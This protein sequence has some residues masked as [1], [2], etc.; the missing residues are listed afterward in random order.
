MGASLGERERGGSDPAEPVTTTATTA[1]NAAGAQV[2]WPCYL[3]YLFCFFLYSVVFT[4]LIIHFQAIR[5]KGDTIKA[6]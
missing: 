4:I 6:E 2:R 3:I 5:M 1:M